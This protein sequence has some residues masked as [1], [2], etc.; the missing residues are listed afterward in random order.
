M[1]NLFF[2]EVASRAG[3]GHTVEL[4]KSIF[5]VSLYKESL[6]AELELP[7][8]ISACLIGENLN[9][10]FSFGRLYCPIFSRN[11]KKI[12]GIKGLE[13]LDKDIFTSE[14]PNIG[15]I[16]DNRF[17]PMPYSG[18]FFIKSSSFTDAKTKLE[19]INKEYLVEYQI[20]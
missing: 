11:K 9:P 7:S 3:G 8:E 14:I 17:I 16:V 4:S 20:L 10:N 18:A 6:L 12:I 1:V 15:D 2:L 13:I 5:G 19:K